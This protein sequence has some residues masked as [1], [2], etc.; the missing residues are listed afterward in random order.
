[1]YKYTLVEGTERKEL[2]CETEEGVFCPTNTSDLLIDAGKLAI[3]V[4]GKVLDLG[5]G[6]GAVGIVLAKLGL[7]KGPVYASDKS[8]KAIELAKRN[9]RNLSVEYVAKCGSLFEPWAGERFNIIVDDVAGI[10]DDI[11][12]VSSWYPPGV[13]C[14]AGRD[15]T[16][17]IVQVIE[18]SRQYLNEQG[19]L[20]FPL[21]SLS[22]EDKIFQALKNTYSS[23]ELIVKK[24]WFLPDQIANNTDVLMSLIN[25]GTIKCQKKYGRWIWSTYI[26]KANM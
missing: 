12:R 20:I 7:C 24:D 5:C 10:S 1:M 17:W 14:N 25:D 21:L 8:K 4:P 9:A 13:D 6:C 18:Q 23:Y 3:S 2:S 19:M 22:N 26:Y 16:R 15:G 11:A